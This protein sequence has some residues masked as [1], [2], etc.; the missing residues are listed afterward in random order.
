MSRRTKRLKEQEE[1]PK[2]IEGWEDL[3][4]LENDE[5]YLD[6]DLKSGNGY[7]NRKSDDE[8]IHYLS[9]HSFYGKGQYQDATL[10]LQECGFNVQ[11]KNWDGETE[12]VNIS[13]QWNFKGDCSLCRRNK[14]CNKLCK[15][16]KLRK[17]QAIRDIASSL[18]VDCLVEGERTR[19]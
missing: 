19:R 4:G 9:T 5:Y 8:C 2:L 15:K 18:I 3:V 11:L 17:Q 6:I 13:E 7:I 1:K 14:F 12:Y 16:A 10:L